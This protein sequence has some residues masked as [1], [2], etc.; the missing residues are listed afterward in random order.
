MMLLV[1]AKGI[2]DRGF[3]GSSDTKSTERKKNVNNVMVGWL[4]EGLDL[5]TRQ[6]LHCKD[7][8]CCGD[9][10]YWKWERHAT[11][12]LARGESRHTLLRQLPART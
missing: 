6:M 9:V 11:G 4:L 2:R 7:I 1:Q 8:H 12:R 5:S 3:S 10:P